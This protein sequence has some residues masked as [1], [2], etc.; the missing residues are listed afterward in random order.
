MVRWMQTQALLR[1]PS[2]RLVP[3]FESDTDYIESVYREVLQRPADQDG[4]NHYRAA[5]RSGLSRT[6]VLLSL[7]RSDEFIKRLAPTDRG[8]PNLRDLR[9]ER[10]TNVIDTTNGDSIPAF[11]V[12]DRTDFDWLETAILR[13]N[14]Y[15]K[16][17]VWNLGIDTDKRLVAEIIAA[18][19][20]KSALELGCAAGAV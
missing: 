6:A 12:T 9:P 1:R 17:G 7:V 8:L 15:E 5:M 4:L 10:F 11:V 13:N 20:S 14:Y 16:P 19:G 3:V 2:A 18:F